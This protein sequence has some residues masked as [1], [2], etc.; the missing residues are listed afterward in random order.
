MSKCKKKKR[1]WILFITNIEQ[2]PRHIKWKKKEKPKIQKNVYYA[3]APLCVNKGGEGLWVYSYICKVPLETYQN[4]IY[5][6]F[7][8]LE[9]RWLEKDEKQVF[10]LWKSELCTWNEVT[11]K[12]TK[13]NP[14]CFNS[15]VAKYKCQAGCH[16]MEAP[17]EHLNPDEQASIPEILFQWVQGR[18]QVSVKFP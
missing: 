16:K 2:I 4:L 13:Q 3:H 6:G 15:V 7:F 14:E 12:K 10:T 8:Q 11:W 5:T 17:R 9:N 18:T 1:T